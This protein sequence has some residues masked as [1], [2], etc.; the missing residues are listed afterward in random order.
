MMDKVEKMTQNVLVFILMILD[1]TTK[2]KTFKL[3]IDTDKK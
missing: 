2:Q 3:G 1:H